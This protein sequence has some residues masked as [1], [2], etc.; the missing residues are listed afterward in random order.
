MQNNI[1]PKLMVNE[2]SIKIS[3]KLECLNRELR[4]LYDDFFNDNGIIDSDTIA[5]MIVSTEREIEI[6][7]YINYLIDEKK[8]KHQ[9]LP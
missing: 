5:T 4:S 9:E 8:S 7:N 3:S 1:T 2:A 6:Y